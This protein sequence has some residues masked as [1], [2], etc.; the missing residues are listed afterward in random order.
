MATQPPPLVVPTL[1]TI[2]PGVVRRLPWSLQLL[3]LPDDVNEVIEQNF[4]RIEEIL[5]PYGGGIPKL[6]QLARLLGCGYGEGRVT[7]SAAADASGDTKFSHDLGRIPTA[8]FLS[9]DTSGSGGQIL[10]RPSGANTANNG[11]F[12]AWT[13]DE[14][15]VR[16]TVT[17]DYLFFLI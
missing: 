8:L 14:I 16:A 3:P 13:A 15:F 12:L 9:V 1:A 2:N 10:G 11:N 4:R 17:A 6:Y 5:R 7:Q